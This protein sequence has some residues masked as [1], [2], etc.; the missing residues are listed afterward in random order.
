VRWVDDTNIVIANKIQVSR[1]ITVMFF[2][3]MFQDGARLPCCMIKCCVATFH[4][5]VTGHC[6]ALD[7]VEEFERKVQ[8]SQDEL[9]RVVCELTEYEHSSD[10]I[11]DSNEDDKMAL[12]SSLMERRNFLEKE[13]EQNMKNRPVTV[14]LAES[15]R[16]ACSQLPDN[17]IWHLHGV[18]VNRYA[19]STLNLP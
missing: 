17:L 10:P 11:G 19:D 5:L 2:K 8:S 4:Q 7:K 6:I 18:I 13:I 14:H 3:Y 15:L 16:R 1:A 9:Y 12:I